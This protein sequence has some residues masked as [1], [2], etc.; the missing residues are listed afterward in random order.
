MLCNLLPH[1]LHLTELTTKLSCDKPYVG[2][3]ATKVHCNF[4]QCFNNVTHANKHFNI[5]KVIMC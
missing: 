5:K 2:K 3:T 4:M 1:I